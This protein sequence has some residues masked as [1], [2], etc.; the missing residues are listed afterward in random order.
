MN[1]KYN[2][3]FNIKNH[4]EMKVYIKETMPHLIY[5]DEMLECLVKIELLNL[6]EMKLKL[7]KN[8]QYSA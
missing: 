3:F 1:N 4:D 6:V 2:R 8:T 5:N 7:A